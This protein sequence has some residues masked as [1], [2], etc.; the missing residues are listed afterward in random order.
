MTFCMLVFFNSV[1][2]G[3]DSKIGQLSNIPTEQSGYQQTESLGVSD[4]FF[5]PAP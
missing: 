3:E 4:F 1:L 2:S 5:F